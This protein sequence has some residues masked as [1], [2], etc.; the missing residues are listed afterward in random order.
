MFQ[1]RPRP[2]WE[3]DA[4]CMPSCSQARA[5]RISNSICMVASATCRTYGVLCMRKCP[6]EQYSENLI[7]PVLRSTAQ[8]RECCQ[9]R[10][11]ITCELSTLVRFLKGVRTPSEETSTDT[12]AC[13]TSKNSMRNR[14]QSSGVITAGVPYC[15]LGSLMQAE[16]SDN[17]QTQKAMCDHAESGLHGQHAARGQTVLLWEMQRK[18]CHKHYVCSQLSGLMLVD[19]CPCEESTSRV[20]RPKTA[21][22]STLIRGG[23]CKPRKHC[24][25]FMSDFTKQNCMPGDRK[26]S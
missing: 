14:L 18:R 19:I 4:L 25:V 10:Q 26:N 21:Q 13:N 20:G 9:T 22:T 7:K 1:R 6:V 16:Q 2:C 3:S 15:V 24:A 8:K 17:R 23:G 12:S 11:M 5:Q